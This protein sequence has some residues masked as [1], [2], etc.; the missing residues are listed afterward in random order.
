[1]K[2]VIKPLALT[3]LASVADAGIHKKILGS[4]NK[5]NNN[6]ILIILNDEMKKIVRIVES[7]EN[8]YLLS[9]GVSETIQ[10]EAKEQRGGFLSMLLGTLGASLLVNK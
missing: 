3:A 7:L 5:I 8:L 9:E 10:N 6:T 2:N 4:G 1:M